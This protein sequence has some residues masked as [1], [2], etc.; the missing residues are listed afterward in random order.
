MRGI[1]WNSNRFKY[2][3]KHK[4]ICDLTKE[5]NLNF[6]AISEIGRSDFTP[7]FLKKLCSGKD[8]L[9]HCKPPNGRSGGMLLGVNLQIFDIGAIDEGDHF[10]KFHLCNKSNDFK[11]ALVVVYGPAQPEQ[12]ENFLAE[13]VHMC[14]HENLP[15]LMGGDYNI[16]RHSSEKN[17]DRYINRWAFL[18]NA[19]I[20][21]LN[22]KE[23]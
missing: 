15:L 21:G 7:R 20:D 23:L 18:F 1:F 17:N 8:Y 9:W 22:P 12:K 3:K 11:W 13:L 5:S 10:I 2:P 6:I 19:I 14:S 16:L 4:Y